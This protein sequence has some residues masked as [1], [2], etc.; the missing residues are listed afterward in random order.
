MHFSIDKLNHDA[1][2]RRIVN[3]KVDCGDLFEK[4]NDVAVDVD[5]LERLACFGH[6]RKIAE[7]PVGELH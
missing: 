2:A 6:G 3:G 4:G 1:I 5:A 7:E